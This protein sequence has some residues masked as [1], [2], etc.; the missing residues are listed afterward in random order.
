MSDSAVSSPMS[1][2]RHLKVMV[3]GLTAVCALGWAVQDQRPETAQ[4]S[5]KA[6]GS[7]SPEVLTLPIIAPAAKEGWNAPSTRYSPAS[8]APVKP[9]KPV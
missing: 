4:A 2:I 1:V 3:A 7:V 9:S 6:W 5:G 8:Q